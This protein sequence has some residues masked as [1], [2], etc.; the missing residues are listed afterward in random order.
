MTGTKT[1]AKTAAAALGAAFRRNGY[2]RYPNQ[3]ARRKRKTKYKKGWEVRL[4]VRTREE[5]EQ[6]RPLVAVAGFRAGK[7]FAKAKQWVL[8]VYG[9]AAASQ[10]EEWAKED[11]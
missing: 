8:P 9:E 11:E 5:T 3:D 1:A 2:I 7:P 10:F 6:L 4:V